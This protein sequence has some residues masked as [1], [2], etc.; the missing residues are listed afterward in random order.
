LNSG[1]SFV[2]NLLFIS[3]TYLHIGVSDQI[4]EFE[5]KER[6]GRAKPDRDIGGKAVFYMWEKG[7]AANE[8]LMNHDPAFKANVV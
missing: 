4:N 2:E 8:Q 7:E 1:L 3:N 5:S 6:V